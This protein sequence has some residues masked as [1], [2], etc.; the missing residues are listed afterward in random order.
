MIPGPRL[1]ERVTG[2]MDLDRLALARDYLTRHG[3]RFECDVSLTTRT[4]IRRGGRCA[5]WVKPTSIEQLSGFILH[6]WSIGL[7]PLVVGATSN[8][9]FSSTVDL[10]LV[11][12]VLAVAQAEFSDPERIVAECGMSLS[13]LSRMCCEKGIAGYQGLCGIPGS[14]GAAAINNSGSY[15]SLMSRNV[16]AVEFLSR[17]GS[18]RL[19]DLD[20]LEYS[21]R[22]SAIKSGRLRGVVLRVHLQSTQQAPALELLKEVENYTQDRLT[23]QEKVRRN[24][25]TTFVGSKWS[26]L[27]SFYPIRRKIFFLVDRVLDGFKVPLRWKTTLKRDLFFLLL[28]DFGLRRHTSNHSPLCFVWE[29]ET[30]DADFIRFARFFSRVSRGCAP[31]EVDLIACKDLFRANGVA[32]GVLDQAVADTQWGLM[33]GGR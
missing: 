33:H 21:E 19:L 18:I 6:A 12:S 25:G 9:F 16:L 24:L 3:I 32:E 14:L 10:D 30:Q 8:C 22:N 29:N 20:A 31:L 7:D 13:R 28:G 4:W 27:W 1:G 17:D 2:E 15:G 5:L 23:N 11:V 26:R